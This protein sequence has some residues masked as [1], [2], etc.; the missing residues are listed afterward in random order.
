MAWY[1]KRIL[2]RR[3]PR[4]PKRCAN[5]SQARAGRRP[6]KS[7]KPR[8]SKKAHRLDARIQGADGGSPVDPFTSGLAN[9]T[10]KAPES[11][12]S[13]K[14]GSTKAREKVGR[15]ERLLNPLKM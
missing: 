2:A 13:G 12:S 4:P 6:K 10:T 8:R 11:R 5:T 14:T 3:P 1:I 9:S 15:P 7:R